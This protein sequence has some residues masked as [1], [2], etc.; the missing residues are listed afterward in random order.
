MSGEQWVSRLSSL[1]K[2]IWNDVRLRDATNL[3]QRDIQKCCKPA[4]NIMPA[5]CKGITSK[6]YEI[7][8][9]LVDSEGRR[10]DAAICELERSLRLPEGCA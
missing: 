4:R 1:L 8:H 5:P 9:R 7:P 6:K 2:V 3:E 10:Y